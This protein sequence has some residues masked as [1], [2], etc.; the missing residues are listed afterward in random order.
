MTRSMHAPCSVPPKGEPPTAAFVTD[1]SRPM[2]TVAVA[3]PTRPPAH[4]RICG[5]NLPKPRATSLRLGVS[6]SSE[7]DGAVEAVRGGAERSPSA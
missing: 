2:T 7:F 4:W 3:R 1:P 5:I 6:G